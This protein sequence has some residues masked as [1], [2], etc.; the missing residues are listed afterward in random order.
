MKKLPDWE[1]EFDAYLNRKLLTP[2]KWGEW[3]CVHFTNGFIKTMTEE[4]LLPEEWSWDSEDQA[5]KSIFKYGKGKGLAS[6][7]DNA[8]KKT[9]GIKHI[10]SAYI[11]KGDFGVYKEE[12][13]LA[14]VFDGFNALGVDDDGL[15]VKKNVNVIKAWR[16]DG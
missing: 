11:T 1:I 15:V 14:C 6:A 12:S 9:T 7:I 16:I 4:S 2:F 13:E 3:D 8:V 5:M 10:E